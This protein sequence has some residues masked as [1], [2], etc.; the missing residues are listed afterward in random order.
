MHHVLSNPLVRAATLLVAGAMALTACERA[1]DELLAHHGVD[2]DNRL[3]YVGALSDES[4]PAAQLG[5]PYAL[6]TRL[7]V[8]QINSGQS[9]LLPEGW[10][11]RLVERDHG[12][13]PQRAQAQFDQTKDRVLFF[14]SVFGTPQILPLLDQLEAEDI[15]AFPTSLSSAMA[16]NPHTPPL[17]ASYNIEAMRGMDWLVEER[18]AGRDDLRAGIIY[19]DDDYGQDSLEGWRAA[20][21]YHNVDVSAGVNLSDA[22]ADARATMTRLRDEG[23]EAVLLATLPSATLQLVRAAAEVDYE[24]VWLANTPAWT[25]GFID[26]SVGGPELFERF[27]MVQSMPYWTEDTPF[28]REFTAALEEYTDGRMVPSNYTLGAYVRAAV[29]FEAFGRALESGDVT[30]R[31]YLAALQSIDEYDVNGALHEPMDLTTLPY[32]SATMTRVLRPLPEMHQREQV[33]DYAR[34]AALEN[35]R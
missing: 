20:G 24:P 3:L 18:Y 1:D 22:L 7:L 23:V 5:R 10:R 33:A 2:V 30:R 14:I 17:G 6:G 9:D 4:G 29:A 8:H 13:D 31:G 35:L 27:Y 15:V 21:E 25:D 28:T 19:Q 11:V 32:R 26:P 34:P 12:Y 16:A